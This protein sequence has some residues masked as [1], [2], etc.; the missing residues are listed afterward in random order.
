MSADATLNLK[1]VDDLKNFLASGEEVSVAVNG[2]TSS[3]A[4]LAAALL[5]AMGYGD[6]LKLVAYT[7]AAEAAQAVAKGETDLAVSHQSQILETYQQGGVTIVCAFDGEDITD[8]AF[9][10]V[11]GVGKYG[12]PYFRNR[13]FI[14]APAGAKEADITALRTLYNDILSDAEMTKWLSETML[15]EVDPMTEAQ[16]KEHIQNVSEIVSKYYDYV[17]K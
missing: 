4:F 14:M 1:T 12:Y 6:Q 11:E 16:V 10:G 17:V 7:S 15:L 8:G 3:E 5:G 9:A 2:A 13:C